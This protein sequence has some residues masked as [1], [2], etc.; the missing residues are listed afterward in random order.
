MFSRPFPIVN[1]ARKEQY[2]DR[3]IEY[4]D[5][6]ERMRIK[7]GRSSSSNNVC[8]PRGCHPDDHHHGGKADADHARRHVQFYVLGADKKNLNREISDP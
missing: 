1:G 8:V 7:P 5:Q 4:R 6:K 2:E 3:H